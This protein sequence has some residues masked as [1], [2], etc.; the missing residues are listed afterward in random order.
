MNKYKWFW[1]R[2]IGVLP[3]AVV[4]YLLIIGL[5]NIQASFS[6]LGGKNILFSGIASGLAAFFFV[7]L[8]AYVAPTHHK[9]VALILLVTIGCFI[10]VSIYQLLEN[11]F[12]WE[13]CIE[14]IG[15]IIGA[16]SAFFEVRKLENEG[17]KV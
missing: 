2:W 16:I 3:V 9:K 14:I 15:Q 4:C 8:G 7:F 5:L 11:S 17:K 12:T 6:W 1:L 10:C 13:L